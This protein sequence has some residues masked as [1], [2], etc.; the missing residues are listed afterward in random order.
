MIS[1][2]KDLKKVL[3]KH[4]ILFWLEHGTLLGLVRDGKIIEGDNDIDL[5]AFY[6]SFIDEYKKIS[7]DLYGA[8]YDVYI[9]KDKMTIKKED[10]HATVYLYHENNDH[11]IR[12]RISK[13]PL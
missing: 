11:I 9:T 7:A 5:S 6:K 4:Q 3:D 2:L 10:K 13:K 1:C 8:G 12:N